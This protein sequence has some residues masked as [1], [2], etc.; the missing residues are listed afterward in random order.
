M[1][2]SLDKQV[3]RYELPDMEARIYLSLAGCK[4][5]SKEYQTASDNMQIAIQMTKEYGLHDLLHRC[6]ISA[7]SLY[8]LKIRDTSKA[9]EMVN[10]ALQVAQ[11]L[12]DKT[13]KLCETLQEKGELLLQIGANG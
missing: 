12:P 5:I 8:S 7:V 11:R 3:D 1:N 9:M 10:L 13:S 4:E 2:S 6:Y